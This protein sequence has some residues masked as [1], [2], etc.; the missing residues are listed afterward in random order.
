MGARVLPLPKCTCQPES[1][2]PANRPAAKQGAN[3]SNWAGG[4]GSQIISSWARQIWAG[5]SLGRPRQVGERREVLN[6]RPLAAGL[7]KP[8]RV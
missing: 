8:T 6:P 7:D 4:E 5:L 1:I 3:L 2:S